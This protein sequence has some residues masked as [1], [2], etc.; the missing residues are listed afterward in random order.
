MKATTQRQMWGAR[1][2]HI[3][4]SCVHEL[5]NALV[6]VPQMTLDSVAYGHKK[7][8]VTCSLSHPFEGELASRTAPNFREIPRH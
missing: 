2:A 6:R 8:E 1:A 3:I 4:P 5:A 7:H